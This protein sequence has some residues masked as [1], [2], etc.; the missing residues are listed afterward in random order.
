MHKIYV[1]DEVIPIWSLG[2]RLNQH[3]VWHQIKPTLLKATTKPGAHKLDRMVFSGAWYQKDNCLLFPHEHV[4]DYPHRPRANARALPPKWGKIS[5]DKVHD[6]ARHAEN[7][8]G[9]GALKILLGL[10]WQ[11]QHS[12][13]IHWIV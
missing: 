5:F 10:T 9:T 7:P 2:D 6:N 4:R 1:S 11:P 13:T 8:S 3:L 12:I